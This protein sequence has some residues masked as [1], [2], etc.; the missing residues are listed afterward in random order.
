MKGERAG[1]AGLDYLR[2]RIY[3][4]EADAANRNERRTWQRLPNEIGERLLTQFE[5]V[6]PADLENVTS[7]TTGANGRPQLDASTARRIQRATARV[8][9]RT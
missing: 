8:G 6:D 5:V 2:L 3:E 9:P 1:E 4:G 7:I